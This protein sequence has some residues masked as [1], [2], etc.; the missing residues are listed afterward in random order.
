MRQLLNRLVPAISDEPDDFYERLI[1][2][3]DA[4]A[5]ANRICTRP[6]GCCERLVDHRYWRRAELICVRHIATAEECR[7]NRPEIIRSDT[8]QNHYGRVSSVTSISPS[9]KITP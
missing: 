8:V 1:N 2:A 3:S 4:E 9:L 5:F 7:S 6:E